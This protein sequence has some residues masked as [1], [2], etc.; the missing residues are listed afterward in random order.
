MCIMPSG[1]TMLFQIDKDNLKQ[2]KPQHNSH[3]SES[4]AERPKLL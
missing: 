2:K 1:V 3:H 4:G